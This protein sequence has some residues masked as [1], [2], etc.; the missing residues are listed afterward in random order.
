[1]RP[2]VLL[3]SGPEGSGSSWI[4][5]T[6]LLEKM[7]NEPSNRTSRTGIESKF[8]CRSANTPKSESSPK[9]GEGAEPALAK[10]GGGHCA[11]RAGRATADYHQIETLRFHQA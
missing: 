6:S 5:S 1:M 8:E 4:R 2:G 7:P 10:K 9:Q 11:A 3:T